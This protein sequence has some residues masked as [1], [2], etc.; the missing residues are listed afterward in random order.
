[1]SNLVETCYSCGKPGR[2]SIMLAITGGR[3]YL[4]NEAVR[5]SE[6]SHPGYGPQSF[7]TACMR[8]IEDSLRATVQYLQSESKI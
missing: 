1:M 5:E 3:L 6:P 2:Y 8:A 4:P 7:C